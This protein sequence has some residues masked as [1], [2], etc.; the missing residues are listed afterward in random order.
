MFDTV[1]GDIAELG[2]SV[3]KL[4]LPLFA[5][6]LPV[7]VPIDAGSSDVKSGDHPGDARGHLWFERCHPG[8]VE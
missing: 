3:L 6:Q 8:G 2:G 7:G 1:Y 5:H 4:V